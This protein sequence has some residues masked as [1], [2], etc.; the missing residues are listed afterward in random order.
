MKQKYIDLKEFGRRM[1][2]SDISLDEVWTQITVG[3]NVRILPIPRSMKE[4]TR[5]AIQMIP[6]SKMMRKM[7]RFVGRRVPRKFIFQ[8]MSRIAVR[9]DTLSAFWKRTTRRRR[10]LGL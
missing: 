10:L 9:L 2:G 8:W 6:M 3:P 7:V 4:R 1:D 5:Q